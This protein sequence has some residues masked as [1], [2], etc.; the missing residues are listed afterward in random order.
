MIGRP[1]ELPRICPALSSVSAVAH[2]V[3]S[4]RAL[5]RVFGVAAAGRPGPAAGAATGRLARAHA[6]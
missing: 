3:A 2:H 1:A 6:G 4:A 5:D